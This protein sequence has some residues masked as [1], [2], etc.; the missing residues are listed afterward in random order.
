MRHLAGVRVDRDDAGPTGD[1]LRRDAPEP[2]T[3][4]IP[5]RTFEDRGASVHS[6]GRFQTEDVPDRLAVAERQ[7]APGG[8]SRL[9]SASAAAF[10]R[11]FQAPPAS[12]ALIAGR[13][14]KFAAMI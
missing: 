4:R 12:A 9:L 11:S 5:L 7:D 8:R 3:S 14:T 2:Q 10:L 6:R 1:R 13:P